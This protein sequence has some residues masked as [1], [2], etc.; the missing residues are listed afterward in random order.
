MESLDLIE[1]AESKAPESAMKFSDE[2]PQAHLEMVETIKEFY[3]FL[4]DETNVKIFQLTANGYTQKQIAK[5]LG[6]K[7]HSAVGKRM[8]KIEEKRQAFVK[9]IKNQ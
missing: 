7:T 6:F 2:D 5:S 4:G 3:A 9:Q 8:K 1:K